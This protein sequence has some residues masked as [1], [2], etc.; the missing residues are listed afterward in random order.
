MPYDPT[1]PVE[2]SPILSAELR[3]QFQGLKEEVDDRVTGPYVDGAIAAQAAANCDSVDNLTA[4]VSNP[5]TQAQVQA[6]VDKLTEL[7]NVLKRI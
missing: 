5:P 2:N 6:L 1:L 4:T 7:M 3:S